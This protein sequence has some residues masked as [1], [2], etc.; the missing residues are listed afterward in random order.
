VEILQEEEVVEVVIM[1]VEQ[2]DPVQMSEMQLVVV[3]L[4]EEIML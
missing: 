4:V 1:E 2:E 3:E